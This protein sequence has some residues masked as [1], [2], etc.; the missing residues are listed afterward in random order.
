MKITQTGGGDQDGLDLSGHD[1]KKQT[2][3]WGAQECTY[4]WDNQIAKLSLATILEIIPPTEVHVVED[5]V[6]PDP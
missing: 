5:I 2:I 3:L 4:R 1:N 6:N